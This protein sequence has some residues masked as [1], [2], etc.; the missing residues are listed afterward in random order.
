MNI[1]QYDNYQYITKI[2]KNN[3]KKIFKH[4]TAKYLNIQNNDPYR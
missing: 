2:S 4:I 1:D 3:N